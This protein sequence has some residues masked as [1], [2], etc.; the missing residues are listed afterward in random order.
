MLAS[1]FE[2][3]FPLPFLPLPMKPSSQSS[4]LRQRFKRRLELRNFV[5]ELILF[6][7]QMHDG[8]LRYSR[9]SGPFCPLDLW[10]VAQR[11]VLERLV[12]YGKEFL[13]GRRAFELTSGPEDAL[14]L[15]KMSKR[16]NNYVRLSKTH[17]QVPLIAD[18]IVEPS[19][20]Q[21]VDMLS[22]LP[23]REASFYSCE[24][25][26]VDLCGK[27]E[28]IFR[29]IEDQYSFVG[30]S[31]S[32]YISYFE[33]PDLPSNMW[34]W[35]PFRDAK[36]ISGFSVVP[37][38]D[39]ITQRKLLMSCSFNYLLT[40]VE[41]RSRLGMDAGGN[42]NRLH[43]D[44]SSM[45]VAACDQSNAFTRVAVPSW[46]F[47]YQAVPPIVASLVWHLLP[48]QVRSAVTRSDLV[49]PVYMR[50]PMG[51]AHSVHILMQINIKI[52][53][54]TI[55]HHPWLVSKAASDNSGASDLPGEVVSSSAPE[56]DVF[57][58]CDDQTW[59]KRQLR[60]RE[61]RNDVGF[62][63]EEWCNKVRSLRMDEERTFVV[64][65]LFAGERRTGDIHECIEKQALFH[66][67][68]VFVTSADLATDSRWD[69]TD[70]TTFSQLLEL[71]EAHIDATGGVLLAP[72]CPELVSIEEW[73]GRGPFVSAVVFGVEVICLT[74][75][76]VECRRRINCTSIRWLWMR[77]S[78]HEA[79][80]T[81]QN[82]P[83]IQVVILIPAC[84]ILLRCRSWNVEQMQ[85]GPIFIN[86]FLV[87]PYQRPQPSP[88]LAQCLVTSVMH[89]VLV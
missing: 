2:F 11:A 75:N 28:T 15:V 89:G 81:G 33:R 85:K 66:G 51:C 29:E 62:S 19:D 26:A 52:L 7:N 69:L 70:P 57:Y 50:L 47:P 9:G 78:P 10:T 61:D 83:W 60:R 86:V 31:M 40:P 27:S 53:G 80:H 72:L 23:S 17:T 77:R 5:N 16:E 71:A 24:A 1:D 34:G 73:L 8:Q 37:K 67:L 64:L 25:N 35:I 76:V 14:R 41:E 49:C 46:F 18:R 6:L 21:V 56:G 84:G 4:R 68:S 55:H 59:W 38:K 13:Q 65:L 32:E 87:H 63:V 39:G 44:G 30:G 74:G 58:G 22:A 45:C 36:A 82:T 42:I 43:T 79:G 48:E 12:I 88:L 54:R 3:L 20:D